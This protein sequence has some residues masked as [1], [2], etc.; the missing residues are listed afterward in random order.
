MAQAVSSHAGVA[1]PGREQRQLRM[2]TKRTTFAPPAAV[3][4]ATASMAVH[5]RE[6]Q[7]QFQQVVDTVAIGGGQ[8]E[9]GRKGPP[10]LYG[11]GR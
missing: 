5:L 4:Y 1:V 9:I 10:L 2:A 3:E 8:V 11:F 7:L 6:I